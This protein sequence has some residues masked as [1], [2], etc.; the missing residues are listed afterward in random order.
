AGAQI[1]FNGQLVV[2]GT[3][4]TT[5][6]A[7][8]TLSFGDNTFQVTSRDAAGNESPSVSVSIRHDDMP[9]T[10]VPLTVVTQGSGK[11]LLLNWP[12]YDEL[13]SAD[14]IA[15]YRVYASLSN[16]TTIEQASLV[17]EVPRGTKT[18]Q[19]TG[20]TRDQ[21]LYVSVVAYDNQGLFNGNVT[22]IAATPVDTL[23]PPEIT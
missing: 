18:T 4:S 10:P 15:M 14:D 16:Y 17:R 5:W 13:A 1:Y 7:S 12:A 23:A 21:Q 3:G 11:E 2:G 19:L 9:P 6:S 20:L 22:P 8:R